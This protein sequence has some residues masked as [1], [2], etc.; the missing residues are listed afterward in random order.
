MTTLEITV[1]ILVGASLAVFFLWPR[2]K[3]RKKSVAGLDHDIGGSAR[4]D[5][6]PAR[7][8]GDGSPDNAD[9]GG[10]DSGGGD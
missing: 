5:S 6:G 9:S 3:Y 8:Q 1:L 10:G 7:K 2:A 4:A